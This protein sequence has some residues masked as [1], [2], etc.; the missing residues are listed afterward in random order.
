[1]DETQA[2]RAELKDLRE[3]V[4]ILMGR[5]NGLHQVVQQFALDRENPT[6][7]LMRHLADAAERSAADMLQSPLSDATRDEHLR[8]CREIVGFLNN[9]RLQLQKD[10]GLQPPLERGLPGMK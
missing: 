7:V 10:S 5:L 1:M 9:A 4:D 3:M 6:E 2:L 8:V